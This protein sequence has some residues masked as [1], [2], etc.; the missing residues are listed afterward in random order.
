MDVI[1]KLRQLMQE[2]GWSEYRL[3][4]EA[5]LPPTT[6]A[7]IFH[8]DTIPSIP[9]LS[10]ICDAFGIS[11][12]D[13]FTESGKENDSLSR[14]QKSLLL[15]WEQLNDKQRSVILELLENMN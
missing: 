6:I 8:R 10:A 1:E 13:F 4:K 12:S 7:N 5:K 2:K 11:L 14:E 9:T 3:A 15:R